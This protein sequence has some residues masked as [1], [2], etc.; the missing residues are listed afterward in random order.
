[1]SHQAYERNISQNRRKTGVSESDLTCF[2]FLKLKL[3]SFENHKHSAMIRGD[4]FGEHTM[5]DDIK[6]SLRMI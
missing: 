6:F 2:Q 3:L 1:M 5:F 4:R